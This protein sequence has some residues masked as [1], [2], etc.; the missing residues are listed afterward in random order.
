MFC[1]RIRGNCALLSY[2]LI[3]AGYGDQ[4]NVNSSLAY[5][6]GSPPNRSDNPLVHDVQFAR[7]GLPPSPV[8]VSQKSSC[9]AVFGG[10]PS[11]R[12]E[13]FVPSSQKSHCSVPALA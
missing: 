3:F 6:C 4:T 7:K 8:I 1:S 5:F 11:V 13:G 12:V 10:K 9:G 2:F